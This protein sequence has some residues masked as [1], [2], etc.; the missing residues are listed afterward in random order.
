MQADTQVVGEATQFVD[1]GIDQS[2]VR[3]ISAVFQLTVLRYSF[4]SQISPRQAHNCVPALV[5]FAG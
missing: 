3:I 5:V 1:A 2:G 4:G